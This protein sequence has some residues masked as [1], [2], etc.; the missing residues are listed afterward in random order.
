MVSCGMGRT[1]L[2]FAS[3]LVGKF[4]SSSDKESLILNGYKLSMAT[5]LIDVVYF[6]KKMFSIRI[7]MAAKNSWLIFPTSSR[8]G[9][10][11]VEH[12]HSSLFLVKLLGNSMT[13]I[14]IKEFTKI[15]N[16]HFKTF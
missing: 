5:L 7:S 11:T 3:P 6:D 1:D 15:L 8:Q 14:I 2:A 10:K 4:R 12:C 9:V 13:L 16:G